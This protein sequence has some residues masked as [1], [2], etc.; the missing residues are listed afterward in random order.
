MHFLSIAFIL[1]K[2]ALET[3]LMT[4]FLVHI[5]Q[6]RIKQ[7]NGNPPILDQ[8]WPTETCVYSLQNYQT[9][10]MKALAIS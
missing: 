5:L 7:A 2:T 1:H 4:S 8:G 10:P 3:L 9:Q 6:L